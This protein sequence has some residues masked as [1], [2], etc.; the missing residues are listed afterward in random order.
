M[1]AEIASEL[2]KLA[3]FPHHHHRAKIVTYATNARF[4]Y[5]ARTWP[6]E[7]SEYAA[8]A[9]DTL[10]DSF[11][12]KMIP[13]PAASD[14][15]QVLLDPSQPHPR[16]KLAIEQIRLNLSHGGWGLRS[17][18]LH[19]DAAVYSSTA[20]FLRWMRTRTS[21]SLQQFLGTPYENGNED[22]LVQYEHRHLT[23]SQD[24]LVPVGDPINWSLISTF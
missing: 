13:K 6:R 1:I 19:L 12:Q 14:I 15:Q 8:Q 2:N 18:K 7:L 24:G 22:D 21:T 20:G 9:M 17:H 11:L 4:N 5:F 16:T 23:G 3:E 10:I